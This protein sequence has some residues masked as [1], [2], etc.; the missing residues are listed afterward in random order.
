MPR[1]QPAGRTE[2]SPCDGFQCSPSGFG[3]Q[4]RWQTLDD[5]QMY[6]SKGT[7]GHVIQV[8]YS[9]R[10]GA[11]VMP[12]SSQAWPNAVWVSTVGTERLI[13]TMRSSSS[14]IVNKLN[15]SSQASTSAWTA[16]DRPGRATRAQRRMT[17][18]GFKRPKPATA[19]GLRKTANCATWATRSDN[20]PD[21]PV[22]QSR[23]TS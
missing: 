22:P 13:G 17:G 21:R 7:C 6:A 19:S 15:G 8:L 9:V 1:H 16:P 10:S 18:G 5:P 4:R 14:S 2:I 20:H 12:G 11:S 3:L 23:P